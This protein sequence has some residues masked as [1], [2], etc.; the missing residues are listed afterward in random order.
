MTLKTKSCEIGGDK[1]EG[2]TAIGSLVIWGKEGHGARVPC[3]AVQAILV[4]IAR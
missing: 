3:T 2:I 4:D 1:G